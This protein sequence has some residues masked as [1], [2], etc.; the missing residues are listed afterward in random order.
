MG[1]LRSVQKAFEAAGAGAQVTDSA[2]EI[3][4]AAKIVVP[5]VGSFSHAMRELGKRKLIGALKEKI[6]AGTPYLG[7]CLGLQ[8]L[9]ERSEEGGK[10][11]G[12]GVLGGRA[13]RFK[14]RLKVPHM[15]WNT[16]DL[17]KDSPLTKGL[18]KGSFFYFVHSYYAVPEDRRDILATTRYG[19]NF[20]SALQRG[21]IFATQFH[22]EKSQT[23]GLKII[24]NFICMKHEE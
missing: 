23:V 21:N 1:N 20:C 12:L 6:A 8:I 10:T 2:A 14:G 13:V 18:K 16:L 17:K 22:P 15:G 19:V 3:E 7:L 9:F 4:R 24:R 11:R 5:G